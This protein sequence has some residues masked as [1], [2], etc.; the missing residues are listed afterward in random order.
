LTGGPRGD[1]VRTVD[2]DM[3]TWPL[4]RH[5]RGCRAGAA[6]AGGS[7]S[8]SAAPQIR[9]R[10]PFLSPPISSSPAHRGGAVP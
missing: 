4:Y 2:L 8:S 5:R 7:A 10:P 9:S 6:R 3:P 1:L